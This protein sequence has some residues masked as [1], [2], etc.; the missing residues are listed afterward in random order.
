M[1]KHW[2][3]LIE[4]SIVIVIIW[5]LSA[6]LI[7]RLFG[8]QSRARDTARESDTRNIA[9]ALEVYVS[10][11][12]GTYPAPVYNVLSY[13]SPS[14]SI[15]STI[16]AQELESVSTVGNLNNLTWYIRTIP[17]D[18]SGAGQGTTI[19][20]EC[21]AVGN[22]YAY[23]SDTLGTMFA[24]TSTKESWRGNSSSCKGIVEITKGWNYPYLAVGRWLTYSWERANPFYD[25]QQPQD[26]IPQD[27][28]NPWNPWTWWAVDWNQ[29]FDIIDNNWVWTITNYHGESS[30][31]PK[32][33]TI[34]NVIN[35]KI[36]EAIGAA[37]FEGKWITSIFVPQSIKNIGIAAFANNSLSNV[38][39]PSGI[40]SISDGLFRDNNITT[41]VI[42][43]SI[44][45]IW[46][47]AFANNRLTYFN[48]TNNITNFDGT[49]VLWNWPNK[50]SNGITDFSPSSNQKWILMNDIRVKTTNDECFEISAGTITAYYDYEN[51]NTNN[52][53]CPKDV[54][55]GPVIKNQTVTSLWLGSFQGKDLTSIILPHTLQTIQEEALEYNNLSSI[56]IPNTVTDI[57][58]NSFRVNVLTTV[59]IPDSVTIIR[60]GAFDYNKLDKV[61]IGNWVKTIWENAF[62]NRAWDYETHW[63]KENKIT[64][65]TLWNSL[66][67]IEAYAFNWQF[68]TEVTIPP[69][70]KTIKIGAFR[71]NYLTKLH[72]PDSVSELNGFAFSANGPTPSSYSP[73]LTRFIPN[74]DQNWTFDV[75]LNLWTKD[76]AADETCFEMTNGYITNFDPLCPTDQVTIPAKVNWE[77]VIGIAAR[78]LYNKN[79]ETLI[80]EN[81]IKEIQDGSFQHNLF[82][83]LTIPDSVVSIGD[84][85][86]YD[87]KLENV[88]IGNGVKTIGVDAFYANK[89]ESVIIGNGVEEIKSNAFWNRTDSKSST[90]WN[91]IKTVD[92]WNSVKIIW[93]DAFFGHQLE[94]LI[95]PNSVEFIGQSAFGWAWNP[96]DWK[97]NSRL[98]SVT[99]W[100]SVKTIKSFAFV[101]N[102]ITSITI[103]ASVETI[104]TYAFEG[105][106]LETVVIGNGVK[107]IGSAAFVSWTREENNI[108][109]LTLW[110]SIESIGD[111]AFAGNKISSSIIIPPTT[112]TIDEYAF[113]YNRLT[114]VYLP[115][116]VTTLGDNAFQSNWPD[117]NSYNINDFIPNTNQS[118]NLS[119]REWIKQ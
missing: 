65:L 33:V 67:T 86:F 103:P 79:I 94:S 39:I 30:S 26:P 90:Q 36:I 112:T 50:T 64:D 71:G 76:W 114:E 34:S 44:K 19:D 111:Y 6:A 99:L 5:I 58:Q 75:W 7:P 88:I 62:N 59:I 25:P 116:S 46:A 17:Q 4:M 117:G 57:G 48:L 38:I 14:S 43:E 3:T 77:T 98:S 49:A 41:I 20:G 35:W 78:A 74:T 37:A 10:D 72:I 68:L 108:S 54:V 93:N 1:K 113:D 47:N 119:E 92:L 16:Y 45:T 56:N 84:Y 29:C 102:R 11:H 118:W 105:N 31:C 8:S 13:N 42:P 28:Q 110:N 66:E 73:S 100:N 83:W 61:V 27:P 15:I 69:S 32:I 87:G 106:K 2:F 22:S 101:N 24:I 23:H 80:I 70:V 91:Q 109:S 115:S 9:A 85:A 51:N 60:Q 18:P 82:T 21:R 40:T 55:M 12:N 52:A 89:L 107:T 96:T 95:I 104:E 53:V 81:G 63:D 97:Y